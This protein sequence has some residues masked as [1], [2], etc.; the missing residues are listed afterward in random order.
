[1]I[2]ATSQHAIRAMA[3]MA[4]ANALTPSGNIA[5][6]TRTPR[7]YLAKIMRRLVRAGLARSLRGPHGGFTLAREPR[8]ISLWDIVEAVDPARHV[9][10][11]RPAGH[12][13]I[14]R[15]LER[16]RADAD[17]HLRRITLD[18]IPPHEP[19]PDPPPIPAQA[20]KDAR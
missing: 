10:T 1:V 19:P 4:G 11:P 12:C 17:R 2:S 15:A 18:R 3:Y 8:A 14:E 16:A 5:Q 13:P 6:A 7:G 20:R 9:R